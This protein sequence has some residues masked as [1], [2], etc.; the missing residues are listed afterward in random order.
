METSQ[1]DFSPSDVALR[2]DLR[3][4]KKSDHTR[5]GVQAEWDASCGCFSMKSGVQLGRHFPITK[6]M[7]LKIHNHNT[8]CP[9]V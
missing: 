6:N 9:N 8:A 1:V 2:A 7:S 3:K 5:Y 4:S